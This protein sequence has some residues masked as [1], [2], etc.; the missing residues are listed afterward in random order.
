MTLPATKLPLEATMLLPEREDTDLTGR[1]ISDKYKVGERLAG[2]GM[3]S[4]YAGRHIGLGSPVA[5]KVVD[6]SWEGSDPIDIRERF[7]RE[8]QALARLKH[9]NIVRVHDFGVLQGDGRFYMVMELVAGRTLAH[10]LHMSSSG[11]L[12]AERSAWIAAEVLDGLHDA[13]R[14]GLVHRDIK[15][16][17]VMLEESTWGE[18]RVKVLDFG[19]AKVLKEASTPHVRTGNGTFMGTVQYMSPEQTLDDPI[20]G[21]ADQY[22]VAVLLYRML[23]GRLPFEADNPIEIVQAHRYDPVPDMDPKLGIPKALEEA[24]QR[25]LSKDPDDRWPD[26]DSFAA[27]IRDAAGLDVQPLRTPEPIY[28]LTR[29]KSSMELPIVVSAAEPDKALGP[30]RTHDSGRR[31]SPPSGS[32]AGEPTRSTVELSFPVLPPAIVAAIGMAIG[33]S[34]VLAAVGIWRLI[35]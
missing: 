9:P 15:P 34:L 30:G 5:I 22:S 26:A 11:R 8:A 23:T 24:M 2:G 28:L 3:G 10:L 12:G 35:F 27:V 29:R 6:V 14:Q 31:P 16:A 33:S 7:R 1:V 25:A 13:H 18:E 4:V 21:R 19:L 20:D 17:N 32:R